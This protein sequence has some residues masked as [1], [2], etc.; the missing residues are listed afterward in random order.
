[1]MMVFYLGDEEDDSEEEMVKALEECEARVAAACV[2]GTLC[3]CVWIFFFYYTVSA[4]YDP[5]V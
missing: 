1:M 3:A 4:F 2:A 5:I